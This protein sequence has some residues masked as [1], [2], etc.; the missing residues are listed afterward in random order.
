MNDDYGKKMANAAKAIRQ[1]HLDTSKLLRDCDGAIWQGKPSIFGNTVTKDLT[2]HVEA[3]QWMAEGVYRWYEDPSQPG[4]AEGITAC[5]VHAGAPEMIDEPLLLVGRIKYLGTNASLDDLCDEW[6]LWEA[7]MTWLPDRE[8]GKVLS[9]TPPAKKPIEWVRI[10]AVPLYSIRKI[11]D[12]RDL[13]D[14]VRKSIPA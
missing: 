12:V 5:F 9:P 4:L 3:T 1:M 7:Y 10:L 14:Q 13:V 2:Y 8:T 6:D 11:E